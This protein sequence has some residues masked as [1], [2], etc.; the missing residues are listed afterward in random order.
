MNCGGVT[1]GEELLTAEIISIA[2]LKFKKD[3]DVCA[4]CTDIPV[5]F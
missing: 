2:L 1:A 3:G 4:P 5:F